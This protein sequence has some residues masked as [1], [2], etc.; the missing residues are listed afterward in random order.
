MKKLQRIISAFALVASFVVVPVVSTLPVAALDPGNAIQNGVNN[1]GGTGSSNNN[2]GDRIQTV[3]N[4]ILFFLGAAAVIMIVIGGIRYVL[5]GGDS[6][7]V[8]SAKDTILYAVIGLV[9]AILAYAI[10]NFVIKS[11]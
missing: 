8:K 4:V 2:L 9:V 7:S 10:V 3:I 6:G 11:F 5:S 1:A